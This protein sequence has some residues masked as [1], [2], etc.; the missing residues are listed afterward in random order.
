M[1]NDTEVVVKVRILKE[2]FKL[3]FRYKHVHILYHICPSQG[4]N[5]V[6]KNAS[7]AISREGEK[8]RVSK[9]YIESRMIR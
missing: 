7:V 3:M 2:P 4:L 8:D 6:P 1:G 9:K 5:E